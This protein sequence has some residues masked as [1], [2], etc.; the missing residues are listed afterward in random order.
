MRLPIELSRGGYVNVCARQNAVTS[1]A[2]RGAGG[3]GH[4][5]AGPP[6]AQRTR[7]LFAR[8]SYFKRHWLF[9][10]HFFTGAASIVIFIGFMPPQ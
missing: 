10:S 4:D 7:Y 9:S 1:R 5:G 8:V 3:R 2:R 6:H